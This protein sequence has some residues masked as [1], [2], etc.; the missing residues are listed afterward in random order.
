MMMQHARKLLFTGA[1]GAS[2][3][4]AAAGDISF[5]RDI[6]P[7]LS[8]NCYACHGPDQNTRKAKLRLDTP[9]GAFT[10]RDGLTPIV[11]GNPSASEVFARIT[12]KDPDDLM[13]PADSAKQLTPRQI[14]LIRDWIAQGAKYEGHWAFT[15]PKRPEA[16]PVTHPAPRTTHPIDAFILARLAREGLAPSPPADKRTLI[17]RLSLDLRGLPPE[18][19]DVERFVRSKDPRAYEEL[20][21]KYLASNAYAER[22]TMQWLDWVRYADTIGFHGDCDFSVWPYRDYVLRAFRD[23]KPFDQFTREQIAGDLLPGATDEQRVASAYNRLLRISTEGGVQDK[24]YLAKYAADRVRT[25]SGVWLGATMG[26]AECHDHKFDP[27]TARDFYSFAAFFADLNERGFYADGFSKNDWGPKLLLPTPEQQTALDA[28]NAQIEA[29]KHG[30][31]SVGD[32]LL[33]EGLERWSAQ[34]LALDQAK[35]LDW[36]TQKPVAATTA[37]GATLTVG[38]DH[39]ISAGGP[40]PDREVYTVTLRPGAGVWHALRLETLT[41]EMFPGNRIARA[42]STFVVT[43]FEVFTGEGRRARPV[44]LAQVLA[45]AEGEGFPARAMLD[46]RPDT[47]W[48]ITFGHS[49]AHQ[50]AFHFAEPLETDAET[51]LTV[52]IRH[53]SDQRR[54][55]IGKFKLGLHALERPSFENKAMPDNV[56]KALQTGPDQ[57]K[58][59][60]HKAI[61]AHYRSVCYELA[62]L[63]RELAALETRRSLLLGRIPSTLVSEAAAT[64]RTM[65]VLPRGN[66]MDDSGEVVEPAVPAFLAGRGAYRERLTRLDLANWIVSP[67]N[68]LTARVFVNRLWKQFFGAGLTRTPEDLGAQG[69]WPSHPDLLDWL[70]CEF[71]EPSKSVESLNG[72]SVKTRADATYLTVQ[73]LNDSTLQGWNV[74]HLIRLLVTSATYRQSSVGRPDLDERDPENRLLARQGRFRLDAELVRDNALAIAGLLVDEF[75][76]ASVKPYQPEGYYLPLNF[77]KREY[78]HGYGGDLYRRGLYTHW[79]R[80]FLHPSLMAFDAPSREECTVNRPNSNTP[81]QALVL[82]NDPTYVEAARVFAAQVLRR[83]GWGFESKLEWAF[84]RAMARPPTGAEADVLTRLHEREKARFQADADAA[85]ALLS[86]GEHESSGRLRAAELAAWTAVT[87]ALLNLHETITRY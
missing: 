45:D 20:V 78:Q 65:R 76:G 51:I 50:A 38:D 74:Q 67:D 10:G 40:D 53:E 16:P 11:P 54:A 63:Q 84:I 35:T 47:G 25:T 80:T 49:R 23:N 27:Y 17:R 64:S 83:G 31:D 44:T 34:V 81:L 61:A 29:L 72:E 79:Q 82:L 69:E 12:T 60:Q 3:A 26:C 73:R 15:P 1:L 24:E 43:G 18:P 59:D 32:E 75:G 33:A 57:R 37:H 68:P 62:R 70:A 14:G 66:W 41:D 21:E 2:L 13:P 8:D 87:R 46:D 56:L 36:Q 71:M 6:R 22:M 19:E 77:P 30:I 39:S 42:G 7:I 58:D 9:E 86:T 5:N 4:A 48:A 85:S 28:L 52:R 55:T